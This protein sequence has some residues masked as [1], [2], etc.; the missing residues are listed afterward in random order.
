[1]IFLG[2][3]EAYAYNHGEPLLFARGRYGRFVSAD[4]RD[5]EDKS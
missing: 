2:A 4:N 5:G 3:V 1:V